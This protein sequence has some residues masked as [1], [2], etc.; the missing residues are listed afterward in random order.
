[1]ATILNSKK[2]AVGSPYVY[3]TVNVTPSNRTTNG[4][5]LKMSVTA[6]LASS[7]SVLGSGSTYGIVGYL[8][9]LGTE[10]KITIKETGDSW[11]GTTKHTASITKTISGLN[12][13]DT[14]ITGVKFRTTRTG[15]KND[16]SIAHAG[17]LG[18]TSCS[19]ITFEAGHTPPSGVTYTMVETN[20]KLINVG[21]SNNVIVENL[22][23][24]KFTIGA[25]LYDDAQVKYALVY[26]RINSVKVET[27]ANPATVNYNFAS[28]GLSLNDVGTKVPIAVGIIDSFDTSMLNK[29]TTNLA[30]AWDEYDFIPYRKIS[31]IETSSNVKRN[32]QT[33]GKVLLNVNGTFFNGIV[34]NVNQSGTYRPIIK[35]KF[36]KVGSSEPSSYEYTVP[37]TKIS[38]SG[39]QFKVENYE[40]GSS[41]ETDTNY[42][43]PDYAYR[44]KIYVED[45][46]TTYPSKEKPISVGEATWTEYKDRV[47]FKKIT[48]QGQEFDH[49]IESGENEK[50]SWEKWA[51]G[52]MICRGMISKTVE[53]G[54]TTLNNGMYISSAVNVSFPQAFADTNIHI[55][56]NANRNA[57]D[58][59][60][61]FVFTRGISITGFISWSAL[62]VSS[63]S[64]GWNRTYE[65]VGKWK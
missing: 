32:G 17:E 55:N 56:T 34:G 30:T 35:Y 42:F 65:A 41:V 22:S 12:A 24:K 14:S 11:S 37:S 59:V 51:S 27:T 46:F 23:N 49:I 63:T 31:L 2:S 13:S 36:W 29:D 25:T 8:K 57:G 4:I 38:I 10:Y 28:K 5:T 64:T 54:H 1:M 18:S 26:N 16:G 62:L 44:V 20:Q 33:S 15:D 19:N 3:Y 39:T 50:G 61:A 40:I 43:N 7:S 21:V 48:I 6:W 58:T 9:I 60:G 53:G 52:K 47:D 45:N